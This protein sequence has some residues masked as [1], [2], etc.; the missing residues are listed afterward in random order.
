MDDL[1]GGR[2]R[3]ANSCLRVIEDFQKGGGQKLRNNNKIILKGKKIKK[4]KQQKTKQKKQ[5][6][7]LVLRLNVGDWLKPRNE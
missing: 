7:T 6:N 1:E 3:W 4:T 5:Q 2:G